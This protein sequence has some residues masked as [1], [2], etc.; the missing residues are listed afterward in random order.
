MG[1]QKK[2][3]LSQQAEY[4]IRS[5][6]AFGQSKHSA[7]R[8]GED[9]SFKS[10]SM[11]SADM[12]RDVIRNFSNY[13]KEQHPEVQRWNQVTATHING[14]LKQKAS[15]GCSSST[16]TAYQSNIAT[17][18]NKCSVVFGGTFDFRT[19]VE[20]IK[21]NTND[22]ELNQL[23]RTHVASFEEYEVINQLLMAKDTDAKFVIFMAANYGTRVSEYATL[24][25]EAIDLK[26]K[27]LHLD[28][29]L[30]VS[31]KGGR[32]RT[33]PIQPEHI[34]LFEQMLKHS[35]DV[36]LNGNHRL[37]GITTDAISKALNRE[38][39][40]SIYG[41]KIASGLSNHS[42]RKMFAR[43]SYQKLLDE[44]KTKKQAMSS[45]C[46]MLGHGE[47]RKDVIRYYLGDKS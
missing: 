31:T 5:T 33:I 45:V 13:I 41:E 16:L 19:G 27:T 17:F 46:L 36:V 37:F 11:A 40:K 39:S 35:K 8:R 15:D 6:N 44:G 12:T 23:V 28:A 34:P 29:R 10:Y 22:A 1:K 20:K 21:S 43:N 30:G 47:N 24:T 3:S 25:R 42:F 38:I 4:V 2:R 14:F 9:T 32:T 26:S 18:G 7:K